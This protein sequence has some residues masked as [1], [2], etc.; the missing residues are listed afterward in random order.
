M[1]VLPFTKPNTNPV[2][3]ENVGELVALTLSSLSAQAYS[4]LPVFGLVLSSPLE[5]GGFLRGFNNDSDSD[6]RI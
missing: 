6:S 5:T 3:I 2:R 1:T 4:L